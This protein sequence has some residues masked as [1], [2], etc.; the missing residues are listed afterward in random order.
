MSRVRV[1]TDDQCKDLAEW[2]KARA[3]LQAKAD[4]LGVHV[5]TLRDAIARGQGLDPEHVRAKLRHVPHE[6]VD[7]P[8]LPQ[9]PEPT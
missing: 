1:F 2:W 7:S 3:S 5:N 9:L 4:E 8:H 6:T